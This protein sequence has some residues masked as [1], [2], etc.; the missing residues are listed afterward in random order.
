MREVSIVGTHSTL[1][2][3]IT[4]ESLSL[5]P[6]LFLSLLCLSV[7]LSLLCLSHRVQ[8]RKSILDLLVWTLVP[9][10]WITPSCITP[11]KQ[12]LHILYM[13]LG[14]HRF[15]QQTGLD[16]ETDRQTETETETDRQ[17]HRVRQIVRQ[18]R[19]TEKTGRY[20]WVCGCVGE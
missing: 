6:Y 1:L 20:G 15:V 12:K 13:L 19:Q 17:T 4:K 11:C 14:I 9:A 3:C 8:L 10:V 2:T 18:D 16:R 7:S 5:S